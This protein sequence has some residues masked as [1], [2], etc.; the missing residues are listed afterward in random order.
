MDE[1]D[2]TE[3]MK[4]E[5]KLNELAKLQLENHPNVYYQYSEEGLVRE[6]KP[7]VDGPKPKKKKKNPKK[8]V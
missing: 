5:I 2:L 7:D 6:L 8:K 3:E 4:D 1:D